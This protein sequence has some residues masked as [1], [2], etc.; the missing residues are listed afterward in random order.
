MIAW[1]KAKVPQQGGGERRE[2]QRLSLPIG[3]TKIRLIGEVMPRYVYWIT[4]TEGKRMPV[5]CLR[6]V[7]EQ[8]KF[9]DS[10]EDPFKE[11]PPDVFSDKPQFAY[12]CNVIDRRD[13][14]IKIFDLKS[15]IYRQIVDFAGNKEY[16]NPADP[17]TGYDI[18]VKK[19]KTGPLPQNVKYTC[20]PARASTELTEEEQKAD[21][22]DLH[23]IFKRQ[24][25]DDQKK[26]M[27]ENTA[28]FA[29]TTSDEFVPQENAEDLD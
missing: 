8:E 20:L 15:T 5:E 7:R 1:D 14:Q 9:I 6:F 23:R 27:L 16:G 3:D 28:L 10:N 25:Y 19:E 12:I 26:W 13:G 24:T 4:T 21:L 18:T 22:F 2:I 11:L 17:K 29:S